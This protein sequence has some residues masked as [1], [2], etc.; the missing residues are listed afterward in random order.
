ME[1]L[2]RP[3]FHDNCSM[4]KR[5]SHFVNHNVGR[6]Y[7]VFGDLSRILLQLFDVEFF[8]L[9]KS[10]LH[11]IGSRCDLW[12]H[13]SILEDT[14][15]NLT[16]V[17]ATTISLDAAFVTIGSF[18]P[19]ASLFEYGIAL[20]LFF[21]VHGIAPIL[22]LT[23]IIEFYGSTNRKSG[24]DREHRRR[25]VPTWIEGRGTTIDGHLAHRRSRVSG[26]ERD[27]SIVASSR[28]SSR[29]YGDPTSRSG[30]SSGARCRPTNSSTRR[31]GDRSRR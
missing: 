21:D 28:D 15:K 3:R 7:F 6:Q 11:W 14:G 12:P 17:D 16:A 24:V 19:F 4:R 9:M 31:D 20:R 5:V 22:Q 2:S 8:M 23:E 30:A 13:P 26:S 27:R 10:P 1:Y 18:Q 25:A 29:N